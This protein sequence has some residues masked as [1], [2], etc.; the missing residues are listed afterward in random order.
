MPL[1][2]LLA[3]AYKSPEIPD[4]LQVAQQRNQLQLQQQALQTGQ[5]QQIGLGQENQLRAQ[6]IQDDQNFRQLFTQAMQSGQPIDPNEVMKTLGPVRGAAWNKSQLEAAEARSRLQKAGDEHAQAEQDWTGAQA[7]ALLKTVG[8]NGMVDPTLLANTI[9]QA[10]QLGYEQ[11]AQQLAGLANQDPKSVTSVLTQLVQASNKQRTVGAEEKTA[12]ARED[13]A[14]NTAAHNKQ[15]AG[16]E[17][18]RNTLDAERLAMQQRSQKN[19]ENYRAKLLSQGDTRL[20]QGQERIDNSPSNNRAANGLTLGQNQTVYTKAEAEEQKQDGLRQAL[21]NALTNGLYVK[22]NGETVPFEKVIPPQRANE[23]DDAYQARVA[24]TTAGLQA[25]MQSRY[26]QATAA[27][28]QAT[29]RKNDA[30]QA[31][32]VDPDVSTE[33]AIAAR[34]GSANPQPGNAPAQ[35]AP[36]GAGNNAPAKPAQKPAADPNQQIKVKLPNGQWLSGPRKNVDAYLK[37]K[38]MSLQQ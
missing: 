2:P 28:N 12:T 11:E 25:E 32:G 26:R 10:H 37:S 30:L 21:G 36:S 6:A 3:L 17:A 7:N 22:P 19:L 29:A 18:E 1:D 31:G 4:P 15:L 33:D 13:Q 20:T 8:D 24:K 5:L 16:F 27:A 34:G 35:Q 9:R 38:G 23:D 14:A